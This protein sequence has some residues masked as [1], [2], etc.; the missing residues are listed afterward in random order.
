MQGYG[1]ACVA[2]AAVCGAAAA[3]SCGRRAFVAGFIRVFGFAPV[4]VRGGLAQVCAAPSVDSLLT[5]QTPSALGPRPAQSRSYGRDTSYGRGTSFYGR[6][7]RFY[8]RNTCSCGRAAR[9]YCRD[10]RSEIGPAV[11]FWWSQHSGHCPGPTPSSPSSAL[12]QTSQ[13]WQVEEGQANAPL[14]TGGRGSGRG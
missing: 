7:T 14:L 5:C 12:H 8:G 11:L 2:P 3:D 13:G 1:F 4:G 6:D 10:T 9:S